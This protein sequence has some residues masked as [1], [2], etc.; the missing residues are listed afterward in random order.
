MRMQ[1]MTFTLLSTVLAWGHPAVA[2]A[3]EKSTRSTPIPSAQELAENVD[4][5]GGAV[6]TELIFQEVS[7]GRPSV[8]NGA[9][10]D[11]AADLM[12]R[13]ELR[14]RVDGVMGMLKAGET[15]PYQRVRVTIEN[16]T[17]TDVDKT[18]TVE[19]PPQ[20][21]RAHGW[22]YA[23]NILLPPQQGTTNPFED[24]YRI[25]VTVQPRET[26][27]LHDDATPP[28]PLWRS[29]SPLT[30]IDE[31]TVSF[32]GVT[33]LPAGNV[34]EATA[35]TTA[36]TSAKGLLSTDVAGAR[37]VFTTTL[38]PWMLGLEDA[39]L[40][41][42]SHGLTTEVLADLEDNPR[43]AL[44][45]QT[46]RGDCNRDGIQGA[47]C[48][49]WADKGMQRGFVMAVL[50]HMDAALQRVDDGD[51]SLTAGA[52]HEWD[53]A[54]GYFQAV[55]STAVSRETNCLTGPPA[56]LTLQDCA[57]VAALDDAF[58]DG[59][60]AILLDDG[61]G[62]GG[63]ARTVETRL[64]KVYYYATTRYLMKMLKA[65]ADVVTYNSARAEGRAFSTSIAHT[66]PA[67]D[68]TAVDQ[69]FAVRD[70]ASFNAAVAVDVVSRLNNALEGTHLGAAEL[71]DPQD[72][73]EVVP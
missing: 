50:A 38:Q 21:T 28:S 40:Y 41:A 6:E 51:L 48:Q 53:L 35:R 71:L 18:L 22:S 61:N 68:R 27:V 9:V 69:A 60:N 46:V 2:A 15:V 10:S 55:R 5:L 30:A 33:A 29:A 1:R 34:D 3:V 62:L 49:Q 70:P 39:T 31:D 4:L 36:F 42:A 57:M 59:M 17:T 19:L 7:G 23:S 44:E 66:L 12:I 11:G 54:W 73:T 65:V 20:V 25:T 13:V 72:M 64:V 45:Q 14:T 37:T 67:A 56:E 58:V 52:A 26:M 43:L 24:Q 32:A 63:F 16:L 8:V 47:E